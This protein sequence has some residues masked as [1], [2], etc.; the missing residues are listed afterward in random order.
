ML[1]ETGTGIDYTFS[2]FTKW[3]KSVGFKSTS[4]VPL[5]GAASAAVA[6]K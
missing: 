4:I 5:A 6:Y 3:A 2:E 1:I